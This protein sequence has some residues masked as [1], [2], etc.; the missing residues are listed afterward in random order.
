MQPVN[1]TT[2]R[3]SARFGA[4]IR[5][6]G[7]G[8]RRVRPASVSGDR[9]YQ[10]ARTELRNLP[11]SPFRRL[12]SDDSDWAAESTCVEAEPVSITVAEGQ[13]VNLKLLS[14]GKLVPGGP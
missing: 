6:A 7:Q 9:P 1:D 5:R 10:A 3:M 8:S 13:E 12:E 11:T 14:S 4:L 2:A